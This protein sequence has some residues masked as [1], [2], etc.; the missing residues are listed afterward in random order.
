YP[1]ILGALCL[2]LK[3]L[4]HGWG[5]MSAAGLLV[6]GITVGNCSAAAA[7]AARMSIGP[8][9]VTDQLVALQQIEKMPAVHSLNMRIPEM[10]ERL[11]ANQFLL[12][13]AQ[14]F[15]THSYEGRLD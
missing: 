8:L 1:V 4:R 2:W 12:R 15:Q 13:K 9:K 10:W 3:W 14:Y 11:W 6:F 7:F 5:W